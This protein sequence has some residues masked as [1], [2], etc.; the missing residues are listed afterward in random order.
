MFKAG[1]ASM[2]REVVKGL[3]NSFL[4]NLKD[5]EPTASTGNMVPVLHNPVLRI[6]SIYKQKE[7]LFL[8]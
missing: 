6:F 7:F 3:S 5:G 8:Q 4:I 2:L 1:T